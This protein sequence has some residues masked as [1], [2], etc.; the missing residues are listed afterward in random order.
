MRCKIDENI[1]VD[2]AD[3][4]RA[5]G[6]DCH[7]V[8]DE[9]LNGAADSH[10]IFACRA[11]GRVLLTMD[12]DFADIRTYPPGDYPGI[13]VLRAAEPD[14]E[15]ILKLLARTLPIFE[16]ESVHQ[17]LWIVAENRVRIRR[18]SDPAI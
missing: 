1:P 3:L 15:R 11:E 6:H 16:Q 13:V 2:A 7:T 18:S 8:Y 5:A 14:R 4:L 9:G 12:M 17:T 10:V